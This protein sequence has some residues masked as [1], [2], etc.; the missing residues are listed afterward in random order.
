MSGQLSLAPTLQGTH[1]MK[2]TS[3]VSPDFTCNF[4]PMNLDLNHK[5]AGILLPL[6]AL[7]G[8]HDLGIGDTEALREAI[9]WAAENGFKA[10]QILPVNETGG[11]NSP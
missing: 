1:S 7:R 2:E 5:L 9:A 11:D 3:G 10:L 4:I 8:R 6:F